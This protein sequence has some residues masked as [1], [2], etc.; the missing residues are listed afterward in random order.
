MQVI[1]YIHFHPTS[2]ASFNHTTHF[3]A[4][5]SNRTWAQC[6]LHKEYNI[7]TGDMHHIRIT[8][9]FECSDVV[10]VGQFVCFSFLCT[11]S[12]FITYTYLVI[13]L[14][15]TV[16]WCWFDRKNFP[17]YFFTHSN[18]MH[19]PYT[20]KVWSFSIANRRFSQISM[21]TIICISRYVSGQSYLVLYRSEYVG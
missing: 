5:N 2:I 14:Y 15:R 8:F 4:A 19:C 21:P 7:C 10:S 1:W 9:E 18:W 17:L 12:Y 13:T 16:F 11:S 6:T 20:T 3:T